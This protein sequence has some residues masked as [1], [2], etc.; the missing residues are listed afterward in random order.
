LGW[1]EEILVPHSDWISLID[2]AG[3]ITRAA[4]DVSTHRS[5]RIYDR[6]QRI[7]ANRDHTMKSQCVHPL[8]VVD[9]DWSFAAFDDDKASIH[10]CIPPIARNAFHG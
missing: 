3:I 7:A 5:S 2:Q 8:Y 9:R 1:L 4:I 6:V 10:G